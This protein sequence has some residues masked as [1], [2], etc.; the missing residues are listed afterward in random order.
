M[1]IGELGSVAGASGLASLKLDR[2]EEA[3]VKGYTL[4]AGGVR[5]TLRQ[6]AFA[7]FA[8]PVTAPAA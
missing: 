1:P 5:I 6:P 3:V 8:V 7:R 2:A 4:T